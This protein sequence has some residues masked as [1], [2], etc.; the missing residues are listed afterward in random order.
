[1]DSPGRISVATQPAIPLPPEAQSPLPRKRGISPAEASVVIPIAV[2]K[3]N[4]P[5]RV[6][7]QSWEELTAEDAEGAEE[8]Q[9]G[10][11]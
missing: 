7:P 5:A 11:T 6:V 9:A 3:R 4:W 8:C 1:E 10:L 2:V